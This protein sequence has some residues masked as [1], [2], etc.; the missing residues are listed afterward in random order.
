[1]SFRIAAAQYPID[2]LGSYAAFEDKLSRWV[3]EAANAS[4]KLLLFPEYASMELASLAGEEAA[5]DLLG[6]I[7]AMQDWLHQADRLHAALAR[8]HGVYIVAGSAP[9]RQP[10]GTYRNIARIF[11]P[12]GQRGSQQKRVMT[13]FE[14]EH[15]K[16]SSGA[17]L[18]VFDTTLGKFGI[19]ICYDAEFPL[20][21]RAMA[22]AGAKV[23]LVPSCTDTF[24]GYHRVKVACAA[25][26]LE[27][28]C[29]VV[30]APTV[31][32]AK[33][34]PAVDMNV[35]S[36]GVFGPPD[37]NFP[38][39]GIVAIGPLNVPEWIYADI[40]LKN[41]DVVR[42]SGDVFNHRHWPEQPGVH[43]LPPATII[44]LDKAIEESP[45]R[46]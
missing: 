12:G 45:L 42:V 36:A 25:R 37:K 29:Y 23:I 33:W 6:S 41:V 18:N 30:Q 17:G 38:G 15:W 26:A 31:G 32:E 24:A 22:E 10:G 19:A 14:R 28:Q 46:G 5:G 39:D 8:T 2:W 34:S 20:T 43:M 27:N 3:A 40:D 4:A 44:D 7:A 1:M 11:A 21:V 16:I 13:R 9:F 35:G